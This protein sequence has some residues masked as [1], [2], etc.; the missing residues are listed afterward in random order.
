MRI[1]VIEKTLCKPSKC[2]LECI[3]FCPV[4]RSRRSVKAIELGEDGKPVINEGACIGCN[5]CVKK[6]PYNAISIENIPDEL[7]KNAIHRYGPNAFKLYGLPIPKKGLIVGI[8]GKNGTGKTTSLRILAGEI[9][10]NLGE[11][12]RNV[13]WSEILRRFRGSELQSYFE[14]ISEKQLK[15]AHKIQYVDLIPK[16]VK[17]TVK[18][19]IEKAD[20]RGIGKDIMSELELNKISNRELK[21]LSGGELQKFLIAAV[22]VKNADV[23]IFDEPSSYL[24]VRERI[25]VA[26]VIR[27][28]IPKDSYTMVA[29]HDLAMLDYLSDNI[30]IIYG[31]PGVYGIVSK[32]YGCRAGINHFLKGY[33]PA[34]NMRIRREPIVFHTREEVNSKL[35]TLSELKYLEWSKLRVKL[36]GFKLDVEPGELYRGEVIGVLGPNGIGKTTFVRALAG[37]L[38][39]LDGVV[40]YHMVKSEKL[41][42]SYKPQYVRTSMF[43]ETVKNTLESIDKNVFTPGYWFYEEVVKPLRLN[44]IRERRVESLSGGE[45]QKLAIAK[46]LITEADLYLLDEPSA[47]LDVEERLCVAKVIRRLTENRGVSAIV[48]EHDV[49]I[50][51]YTANRVMVF[52]GEP[53]VHGIALKPCGLR[54]G[55]NEFLKQLEVTFRRDPET[56]RPRINKKGSFL[57]RYQKK[58]GEYY[59]T[60]YLPESKPG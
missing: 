8:I 28:Y 1:A 3:R 60:G 15:V 47:Y 6:C 12:F 36:D 30:C 41:R 21:A 7:E 40:N 35:K 4:N 55:M 29:E 2:N 49:S 13:T 34:E 57:D 38:K 26:E 42:I 9:I 37:E 20:E 33:L 51:D 22:L 24:D 32:P 27:E 16:Y 50:I 14:K 18:F 5:I 23:Y 46:T 48:V 17:G 25:R 45:L 43:K 10:P 58:I 53:G 59:Y 19:L 31:E 52:E 56:G 39:V 54:E 11:C 44:K